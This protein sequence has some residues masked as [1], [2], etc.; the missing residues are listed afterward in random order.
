MQTRKIGDVGE[1]LAAEHIENLGY[2]IIHKN[3][4]FRNGEIDLICRDQE[5]LV[6]VEVKTVREKPD[7]GFSF[8]PPESWITPRKRR[9]LVLTAEHYLWKHA[10][11]DTGCR[12]D[13]VF[14]RLSRKEPE[15]TVLRNAFWK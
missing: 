4:K 15:V 14:V 1:R 2:R 6:F 7:S 11:R 12:F 8:G 13:V 10:V 9:Q 3:Y 5:V